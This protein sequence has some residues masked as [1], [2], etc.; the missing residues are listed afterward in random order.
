MKRLEHTPTLSELL[1]SP[2]LQT[3]RLDLIA[4][5]AELAAADLA[6]I[7]PLVRLLGARHPPSWPPP[8][9]DDA[10][11]FFATRLGAHPHEKGWWLW[12]WMD[13]TALDGSR[14]L[15]GMGGFKGRPTDDGTVEIGYSVIPERQRR[16]YATEA[17][18]A[19]IRHALDQPGVR[20]IVA[21]TF[22]EL[23]PS[24]RVL[25]RS[26]FLE[27]DEPPNEPGAMR[28]ELRPRG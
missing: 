1:I 19:L 18:A 24:I 6:G 25:E 9:V 28:F 17:V 16:G 26:G 2:L 3:P 11:Q 23:T 14:D 7:D 5:S 15:V 22:A 27:I 12:Y 21:E 10:R 4:A 20:R 13:R 8:L